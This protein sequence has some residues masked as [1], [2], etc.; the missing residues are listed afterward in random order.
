MSADLIFILPLKIHTYIKFKINFS[1]FDY[2]YGK[3]ASNNCSDPKEL[4]EAIVFKP[5]DIIKSINIW[6]WTKSNV[7]EYSSINEFK[8]WYY[9]DCKTI[10]RCVI[11]APSHEHSQHGIKEIFVELRVNS[12]IAINTPGM[13]S[14]GSK[15]MMYKSYVELGKQY[16]MNID[17]DIYELLDYGGE[18]CNNDKS[19]QLDDCNSNGA[20]KK[21]METIGCT[22]PYALNKTKICTDAVKAGETAKIYSQFMDYSSDDKEV[23]NYEGCYY[24]CSYFMVSGKDSRTMK[25]GE[26]YNY[27]EVYLKFEQLIKE[28]KSY[29]AYSGLSLIAEIG[30]YV[31][32]FLGISINQLTVLWDILDV[33]LEKFYFHFKY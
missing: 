29:Y 21:S 9:R 2:D 24:P 20:W 28:T 8:D 23:K 27:A 5:E 10:G 26:T 4:Y 30:G 18:P 33:L 11:L 3:W 31:G 12:T 1:Y 17:Y 22:S 32:L 13:L 7:S 6:Y 25:M 14:K 15:M 19:Y 16:T